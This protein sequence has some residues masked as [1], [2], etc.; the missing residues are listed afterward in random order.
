MFVKNA[1][2]HDDLT[3]NDGRAILSEALYN[4]NLYGQNRKATRPYNWILIHS[5]D[6]N[7]AIIVEVNETKDNVEIV[8]WHYLSDESLERKKD[9]RLGREG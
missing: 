8:N 5:A 3:A 1:K 7:S 2:T 6:T 9:K 4:P